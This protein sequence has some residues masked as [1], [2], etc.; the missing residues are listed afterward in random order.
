MRPIR[1][2]QVLEATAGGTRRHL[3]EVLGALSG[4]EFELHVVCALR[5]DP[6]FGEDVERYLRSGHAVTIL[7][8]TRGPHPFRDPVAAWRLRRLLADAPCDVLHLHSAKAGVL[9]R[10]ACRGRDCRVIYSPHAFPF[11]QRSPAPVRRTYELVERVL[12]RRT[13]L[14]LAVSDAEARLAVEIGLYP[15]DRVAVLPN[16]LDIDQLDREIAE[17]EP[18]RGRGPER[19]FA[20]VGELRAQ[21]DPFTFLEAARRLRDR[22]I[23]AHFVLPARGVELG[24]VRR[25]LRRHRLEPV[26]DLVA[27][28]TS[29]AAVY[30]RTDV[31][32]LPSLW[33][34]LPYALLD[35]LALRRPVI[36][37]GLPVFEDLLPTLDPRL[38][39][40]PG[41]SAALAE[42]M[43]LL[44]RLP[45]RELD[46]LGDRGRE[47][48]RR[49]HDLAAWQDGLRETYRSTAMRRP[50]RCG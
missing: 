25:Y 29:L 38:L 33:E 31:A 17:P 12:A 50:S 39:F 32:V 20:L 3:N 43:E 47:L 35:A 22:R 21:K 40:P 24:K 36:A 14:L 45:R 23:P 18:F 34:G 42:R 44:A 27:A 10:L 15:A 4:E 13:D 30:R 37:S 41:S 11:L 28:E 2:M 49:H 6:T 46:S 48:V 19:T 8:M 1:I 7:P 26:V 9:G 16:A 5:R